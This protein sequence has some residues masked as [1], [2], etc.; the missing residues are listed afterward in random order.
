MLYRAGSYTC[1]KI[2]K[3]NSMRIQAGTAKLKVHIDS[4]YMK[5]STVHTAPHWSKSQSQN[6]KNKAFRLV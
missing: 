5:R 3:L 4:L 6:S 1:Y 2:M